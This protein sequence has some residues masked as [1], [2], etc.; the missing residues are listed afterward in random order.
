M[1]DKLLNFG[2]KV[3]NLVQ[4]M[5]DKVIKTVN[6]VS[7]GAMDYGRMVAQNFAKMQQQQ[8]PEMGLADMNNNGKSQ[9]NGGDEKKGGGGNNNGGD[10]SQSSGSPKG[11][12][13]EIH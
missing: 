11:T 4:E 5:P 9:N 12:M 1:G 3:G 2:R 13:L 7:E 6:R 10:N 8:N